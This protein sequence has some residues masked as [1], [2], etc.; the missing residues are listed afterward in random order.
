MAKKTA[1]I[2]GIGGQ[3]GAYLSRFLL[4][5][6]YRVHGTS[7]DKAS[8]SFSN[9]KRLGLYD[10]VRLHSAGLIDFRS[11]YQVLHAVRPQEIYNLA[12][13]SSVGLSFAQPIETFES[14][15]VGAQNVLEAIR[16]MGGKARLYNASSGECF[17]DTGNRKADETTAFRPRSPYGVAKA[18][19]FWAV[20]N[21][22][23]AY[24]LHASSGILFN[25]ESP[26][27]PERFVTRKITAAA[28]R[29]AAGSRE[30]LHLGDIRIKRDWGWAPDYVEAMWAMLQRP[31]GGD[32]VLATGRSHSLQEFVAQAFG[33]FGLDWRR[34]VKVDRSLFRP[35]EI[36]ANRGDASKARRELGWRPRVAMPELARLMAEAEAHA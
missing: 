5:K 19:A 7:R 8:T 22:R 36:R 4:S 33:Y 32:Y 10:K 35:D 17:G 25:H 6:G 20:A 30:L 34:H 1:L 27:R 31:R 13:Q 28:A 21:Y 29:I 14:V 26:L 12:G 23:Q 2:F 15:T 3:D 16:F 18:A 11:V 24:G 9:L